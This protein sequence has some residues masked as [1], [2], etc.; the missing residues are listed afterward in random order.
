MPLATCDSHIM[1]EEWVKDVQC[2]FRASGNA[3]YPFE[4]IYSVVR[5]Q[6]KPTHISG[7][8]RSL[9]GHKV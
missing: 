6:S 9:C 8:K 5:K 2:L 3:S 7:R 4:K 1:L